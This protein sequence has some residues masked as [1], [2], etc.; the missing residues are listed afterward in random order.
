MTKRNI[1]LLSL[2]A[3]LQFGGVSASQVPESV[4]PTGH[5]Q[6]IDH[7]DHKEGYCLDI[8]GSGNYVRSDLPLTAHSCKPSI[9]HDEHVA[10]GGNGE[11]YLPGVQLCVTALALNANPLPNSPLMALPCGQDSPFVKSRGMQTFS[12]IDRNQVQLTGT[13]LCLTAG[14]RSAA[15]FEPSHSWRPLYLAECSSAP[16]P[17]SQWHFLAH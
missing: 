15:T 16:L 1:L 8:I 14:D 2:I 13:D 5:L 3:T 12:F 10:L 6:L 11:L 7:L 4:G 9:Y 17:L